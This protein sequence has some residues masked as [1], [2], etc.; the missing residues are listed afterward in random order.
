MVKEVI[1]VPSKDRKPIVL[2]LLGMTTLVIDLFSLKPLLMMLV[3]PSGIV[4]VPVQ[5]P[6]C[7]E[8]ALFEIVKV[9]LVP[10]AGVK[11]V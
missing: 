9:P 1:E 6:V 10:Q 8:T 7:P 3:T 4:T 5:P 2:M 11:V